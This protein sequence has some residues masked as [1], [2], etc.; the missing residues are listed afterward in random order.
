MGTWEEI[1]EVINNRLFS[2]KKKTAYWTMET[3][4]PVESIRGTFNALWAI[5][6]VSWQCQ[7]SSLS[8]ILFLP[9]SCMSVDF[10]FVPINPE[11]FP[12]WLA[13]NGFYLWILPEVNM[14]WPGGVAA[15]AQRDVD[16]AQGVLWVFSSRLPKHD[17]CYS[18]KE[19]GSGNVERWAVMAKM[20]RRAH[21]TPPSEWL[22][23]SCT[24]LLIGNTF[25]TS[26]CDHTFG[27]Q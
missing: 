2:Q 27:L 1:Q 12:L 25:E 21:F 24:A 22:Q 20:A 18:K 19:A 14:L 5:H 16:A 10:F 17:Y 4:E 11:F 3:G 6:H 8:L 26:F 9:L 15:Q 7:D 23:I 13:Q